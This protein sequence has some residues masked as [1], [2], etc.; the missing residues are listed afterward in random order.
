MLNRLIESLD[1]G[2]LRRLIE[3]TNFRNLVDIYSTLMQERYINAAFV[4]LDSVQ[5]HQEVIELLQNKGNVEDDFIEL[6]EI[7]NKFE[8]EGLFQVLNYML[9]KRKKLPADDVSIQEEE[10]DRQTPGDQVSGEEVFEKEEETDIQS[11]IEESISSL[12]E[13]SERAG[14]AI[15]KE[16]ASGLGMEEQ[17]MESEKLEEPERISPDRRAEPEQEIE[18]AI[19]LI[20]KEPDIRQAELIKDDERIEQLPA[21]PPLPMQIMNNLHFERQS[22][23]LITTC[24]EMP[25]LS[26][27]ASAVHLITSTQPICYTQAISPSQA[28]TTPSPSRIQQTPTPDQI[29]FSSSSNLSSGH[30]PPQNVLQSTFL[31]TVNDSLS[32]V[33]TTSDLSDLS[34]A[35]YCNLQ[36]Q[37]NLIYSSLPTSPLPCPIAASLEQQ[38]I[39]NNLCNLNTATDTPIVSSNLHIL[40]SFELP[41][42]GSVLQINDQAIPPLIANQASLQVNLQANLQELQNLQ[43]IQQQQSQTISALEYSNGAIPPAPQPPLITTLPPNLNNLPPNLPP[44]TKL[45]IVRIEKHSSEP[46]GAT[47]KNSADGR[48]TIGRIVCGGAGKSPL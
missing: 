2:N 6:L 22:S 15:E 26:S 16:E 24:A 8:Y 32:F 31:S 10:A 38:S 33:N 11:L 45:S 46:L 20:Q 9:K 42:L 44:N 37:P 34:Q 41:A 19:E 35:P 3:K 4:D 25:S 27:L 5:L 28:F 7:L 29:L 40:S 36:Q 48:V 13:A 23:N 14:F 12:K 43:N 17:E 18:P 30:Q 1:D 21:V 47:V 39:Q